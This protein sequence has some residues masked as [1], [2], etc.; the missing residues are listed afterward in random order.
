MAYRYSSA[1]DFCWILIWRFVI[2]HIRSLQ[3]PQTVRLD[4]TVSYHKSDKT[5]ASNLTPVFYIRRSSSLLSLQSNQIRSQENKECQE[6]LG[7][8]NKER[9]WIGLV[10]RSTF[11][12]SPWVSTC[13]T[14]GSA[15]SS[16]SLF[17]PLLNFTFLL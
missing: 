7:E 6:S 3:I 13:S 11:T 9:E 2:N 10:V 4:G 5:K 1:R 14:G 15:T 17:I 12:M 16:V 8:E